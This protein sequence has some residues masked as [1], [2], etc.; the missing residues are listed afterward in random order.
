VLLACA[1]AASTAIYLILEL[2]Q[3]FDG[4]L[5]IPNHSLRT[6]LKAVP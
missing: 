6:A 3:P 5:Q 2:G 4:L 1:L